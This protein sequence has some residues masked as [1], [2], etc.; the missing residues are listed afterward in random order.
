MPL[1]IDNARDSPTLRHAC[2]HFLLTNSRRLGLRPRILITIFAVITLA[3]PSLLFLAMNLSLPSRIQIER[4]IRE[5]VNPSERRQQPL[6]LYEKE[7]EEKQAQVRQGKTLADLSW[8][9][10]GTIFRGLYNKCVSSGFC[11]NDTDVVSNTRGRRRSSR[12]ARETE[13]FSEV[14]DFRIN[15]PKDQ[16][17]RE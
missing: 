1:V 6:L 13:R 5:Q 12:L 15:V 9:D 11:G 8:C 16:I 2:K 7:Q 17:K 3:G 14:V 10:T 4:W